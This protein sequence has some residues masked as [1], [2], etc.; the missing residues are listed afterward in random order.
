MFMSDETSPKAAVIAATAA[1]E[2]CVEVATYLD[3]ELDAS[4]ARSFEQHLSVC[5][6]CRAHLDDQRRV[7]AALEGAFG[8]SNSICDIELPESYAR[9]VAARAKA[10]VATV[11]TP[12][13]RRHAFGL[14]VALSFATFV[15]LGVAAS[16]KVYEYVGA[17]ARTLSSLTRLGAEAAGDFLVG[18]S[19]VLRA[20]GEGVSAGLRVA[21]IV[22]CA[23]FFLALALLLRLI[24]A[25]RRAEF[26]HVQCEFRCD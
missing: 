25:Y 18:A 17:V 14:C 11:R 12:R 24:A 8:M 10:D 9:V 22:L 16:A 5:V 7:L 21:P 26:Q 3:D 6:F 19:V 15:V 1:C 20:A 13:E 4:A 23:L 2:Q